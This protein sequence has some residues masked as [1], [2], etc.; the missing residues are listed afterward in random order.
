MNTLWQDLRYRA[1]MILKNPSLTIVAITALALGTSANT[2][3]LIVINSIFL[4]PLNYAVR[5]VISVPRWLIE[6]S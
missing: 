2:A 4:R 6:G 5:L 3:I 1:R